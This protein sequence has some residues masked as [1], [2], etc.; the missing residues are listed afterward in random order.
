MQVKL[1]AVSQSFVPECKTPD[2]LIAY[3]ARVSNPANQS[4]LLTAPALIK[5]LVTHAHWSPFEMVAQTFP[6]LAEVL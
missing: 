4:N 1:I 5:Y 2:E 6:S 3:C